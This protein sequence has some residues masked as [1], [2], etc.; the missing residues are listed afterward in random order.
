MAENTVQKATYKAEECAQIL[1]VHVRTI[2]SLCNRENPPF[3][4]LRLAND[5]YESK[6]NLSTNGSTV[7]QTKKS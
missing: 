6:K 5:A 2:Y 1:S 7:W 4:V 3:K